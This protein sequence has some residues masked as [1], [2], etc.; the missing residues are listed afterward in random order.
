[1]ESKDLLKLRRV[2]GIISILIIPLCLL[3]NLWGIPWEYGVVDA[4]SAFYWTNARNIFVACIS[5]L[6]LVYCIYPG[7]TWYDRLVNIFTA[8]C[9]VG[10]IVFPI[11]NPDTIANGFIRNFELFPKMNEQFSD[12]VHRYVG[13]FN[14]LAQTINVG[15]LF[16]KHDGEMTKQ[17]KI[18]NIIYY[19][20][21]GIVFA[22]FMV[23]LLSLLISS[24]IVRFW[25]YFIFYIQF[26]CFAL[27]GF[28]WL[29]K[30]E[31][32]KFL[33]DKE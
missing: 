18:R 20:S 27:I 2:I 9:L 25:P 26:T 12:N 32:F 10:I 15:L 6:A 3:F 29:V 11:W 5:F 8:A 17:K 28:C 19:T 1:M 23:I 30:G 33:N 7:Y 16:T 31:A 22:L 24:R 14:M 13:A 21:A 4:Y